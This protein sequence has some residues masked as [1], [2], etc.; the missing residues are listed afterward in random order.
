MKAVN[1]REFIALTTQKEMS[2]A[3]NAA[4]SD[5]FFSLIGTDLD[6]SLHKG[7]VNFYLLFLERFNFYQFCLNDAVIFNEKEKA[8][9]LRLVR[10]IYN[11]EIHVQYLS[12]GNYYSRCVSNEVPQWIKDIESLNEWFRETSFPELKRWDALQ[13][14]CRV[15]DVLLE[16]VY[17]V[18]APPFIDEVIHTLKSG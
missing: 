9:L 10:S 13:I 14:I 3:Y 11:G 6:K 2:M 4:F 16:G 7:F 12:Q 17:Q 8:A 1:M 5:S 15:T 18:K